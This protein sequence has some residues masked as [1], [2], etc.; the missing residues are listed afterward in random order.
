MT[1]P[2]RIK[3]EAGNNKYLVVTPNNDVARQVKLKPGETVQFLANGTQGFS[4][5]EGEVVPVKAPAPE[6]TPQPAPEPDADA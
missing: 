3:N 4:V 6:P 2:F 1:T 5:A